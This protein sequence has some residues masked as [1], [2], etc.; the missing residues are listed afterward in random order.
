MPSGQA[1]WRRSWSDAIVFAVRVAKFPVGIQFLC[2]AA[3]R[4]RQHFVA[5]AQMVTL[6]VG[7]MNLSVGALGGM[8]AV[9]FGGMMEVSAC[10]CGSRS[11]SRSGSALGVAC[12][13]VFWR[14]APASTDSS[15]RWRRPPSSPASTWASPNPSR[16]TRCRP[17]CRDFGNGRIGALPFLL[18]APLVVSP[19]LALLSVPPAHWPAASGCG[20]Q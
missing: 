11:R 13:T 10:R 2:A 9:L 14:R 15:S 8:V 20:R 16:S 17:P 5:F 7:E 1:C 4:L 12:S 6:A 3:Q 18:I 19:L